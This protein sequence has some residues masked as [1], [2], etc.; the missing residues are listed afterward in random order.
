MYN[1]ESDVGL[2]FS[3]R[4]FNDFGFEIREEMKDQ[5]IFAGLNDNEPFNTNEVTYYEEKDMRLN[6]VRLAWVRDHIMYPPVGQSK[7]LLEF[8]KAWFDWAVTTT[9]EGV[10]DVTS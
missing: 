6:P 10:L 8:Y 4:K 2:C 9:K 3:S 5:F 7:K 1:F